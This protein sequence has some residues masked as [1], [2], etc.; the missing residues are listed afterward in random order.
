MT[1]RAAVSAGRRGEVAVGL[2][3]LLF[4]AIAA[5]QASLIPGEGVGSSVGPNV[6]PWVVAAMMGLFG[7][8]LS[9]DALIRPGAAADRDDH[10]EIDARA[11]GWMLFGLALNA[12]LIEHAGFIVS[13]TLLFICTARAFGSERVARDAVVGFTLA[14]A[15]YIGFDRLLGYKIG[16]GLIE[17]LF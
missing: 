17:R 14:F 9:V 12:A 15:A 5:W 10:G 7:A 1:D 2:G 3:T 13:S 4:A 11:A 16:T 6:V 8:A